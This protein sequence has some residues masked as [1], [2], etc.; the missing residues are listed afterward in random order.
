MRAH[1]CIELSPVSHVIKRPQLDLILLLDF[2]TMWSIARNSVIGS[3]SAVILVRNFA[4]SLA[5]PAAPA[6]TKCELPV[7]RVC[8]TNLPK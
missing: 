2:L 8:L 3:S 4:I 5:N 6:K 7:T 1:M